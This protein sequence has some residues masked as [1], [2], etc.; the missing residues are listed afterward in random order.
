MWSGFDVKNELSELIEAGVVGS[1]CAQTYDINGNPL[2]RGFNSHMIGITLDEL[3]VAKNVIAVSGGKR[4]A[5]AVLGAL[6]GGY[7]DVLVTDSQ[8][9]NE[10]LKLE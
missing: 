7:V 2:S 4:K 9:V 10:I 3:K 6:R 5:A 8:C 1:I